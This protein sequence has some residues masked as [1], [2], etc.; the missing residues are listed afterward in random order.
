VRGA[1]L[2]IL[3][4]PTEGLDPAM[5]EEL[6]QILVGL[7]ASGDV[8]IFFSSHQ[9]VEVEQI[10]DHVLIIHRGRAVVAGALDELKENYRRVNMT[11]NE[12]APSDLSFATQSVEQVKRDGR[13][14]SL[15]VSRNVDE[16][17][18]QARA[19]GA[20]SIDVAPVGLKEIFLENVKSKKDE[21]G[22][23]QAESETT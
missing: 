16:V 1:E 21:V 8:T 10:A 2:L 9:I 18:R 13:W 4:E 20:C 6:L 7:V 3:D 22:R 17:V 15:L 19:A 23:M 14:L 11:F 5:T 12:A